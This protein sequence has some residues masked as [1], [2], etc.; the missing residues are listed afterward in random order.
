[1]N[2]PDRLRQP[3]IFNAQILNAQVQDPPQNIRLARRGRVLGRI[4]APVQ[5]DDGQQDDGQQ[6][7]GQQNV[8]QQN[9]GQQNVG[10]QNV[11]Q[12]NVGQQNPLQ[13]PNNQGWQGI[14]PRQNP[15]QPRQGVVLGRGNNPVQQ[16]PQP[17]PNIGP[18]HIPSP[19]ELRRNQKFTSVSQPL[20]D[21]KIHAKNGRELVADP[22]RGNCTQELFTAAENSSKKTSGVGGVS[23]DTEMVPILR[24]I[25]DA[26]TLAQNG[27]LRD[28]GTA[29]DVLS[30][31]IRNARKNEEEKVKD[32]ILSGSK[33]VHEERVRQYKQL[34]EVVVSALN[35]ITRTA[36]ELNDRVSA[37]SKD[38]ANMTKQARPPL[39]Q[40]D[41]LNAHLVDA[42]ETGANAPGVSATLK[43]VALQFVAQ[44]RLEL[45]N[46][47]NA[48]VNGTTEA[49]KAELL[50]EFGKCVGPN[51]RDT[52]EK[53]K[54]DSFFLKGPDG[55][56]KYVMKP[57]QGESLT[58]AD[59][60]QGGGP[61][62]EMLAS[63]LNDQLLQATGLNCRGLATVPV[64]LDDPSFAEG[65]TLSKDSKRVGSL[66]AV[67]PGG[68]KTAAQIFDTV[69][70]TPLDRQTF[71]NSF[72][73]DDC[74]A[75]AV[76][77][78]LTMDQDAHAGNFL[79]DKQ[80]DGAGQ[81]RL[82]PIDAGQS[83]PNPDAAKRNS[84]AL[85]VNRPPGDQFVP[86]DLL[87]QQLPAA[88]KPFSGAALLAIQQLD[89]TRM[90]TDL[91]TSYNQLALQQPE[92]ANKVDP[93]SFDLVRKSGKFLKRAAQ[94]GLT[95]YEISQVYGEG[96]EAVIDADVNGEDAALQQALQTAL[97]LKQA[98][99][100]Q[101]IAGVNEALFQLGFPNSPKSVVHELRQ[102]EK[103][104][105]LNNH[106][107]PAQW[108]QYHEGEL[109]NRELADM[110]RYFDATA[111]EKGQMPT[112]VGN[113]FQGK[114]AK[115]L[116]LLHDFKRRGGDPLLRRSMAGN[117]A[118]FALEVR[119]PL[120]EK[121]EWNGVLDNASVVLSEC[122]GSAGLF[123]K[124]GD[125]MRGRSLDDQ[126][127]A[128]FH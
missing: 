50:L 71:M 82:I 26:K 58:S 121:L 1:M 86:Q 84:R 7:D 101:G 49:E 66:Q 10:Q 73:E 37:L 107:N 96:F 118:T 54:S 114:D 30:T 93:G 28:A 83:L 69:P 115:Y 8:G 65:G 104:R 68:G 75:I 20:K 5:Q 36:K 103:L 9:V 109:R 33:K 23:E 15:Q 62:R 13:Q 81:T 90:A 47:Y 43:A 98:G 16:N 76:R 12:Q 24:A 128:F 2:D 46:A 59:W 40:T 100:N 55:A 60:V 127:T 67:A 85:R 52:D 4:D 51:D 61:V 29:L 116:K 79:V 27:N 57:I 38:V 87:I 119:K 126:I 44:A 80:G 72:N 31:R 19:A 117:D 120:E 3:R 123:K 95:L 18:Q 97:Q 22:Y 112:L 110:D 89:P 106:W 34:E 42:L 94:A 21:V 14:A 25:L 41:A 99:G 124:I 77:H 91:Q 70:K 17:Q 113:G 35:S 45:A 6:D 11:G 48:R 64:S 102:D 74:Q 88:N 39:N 53:G 105:I 92:M 111:P 125:N 63:K 108:E 122:G 78:F 32:A 56:L